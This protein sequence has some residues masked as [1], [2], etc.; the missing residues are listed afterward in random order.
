MIET[1]EIW[2]PP[3]IKVIRVYEKDLARQLKRKG[4]DIIAEIG[5]DGKTK[6]TQYTLYGDLRKLSPRENP[7]IE[8]TGKLKK[9]SEQPWVDQRKLKL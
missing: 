8:F 3:Q 5:D 6:K 7:Y 9:R 2:N 1:K 4:F